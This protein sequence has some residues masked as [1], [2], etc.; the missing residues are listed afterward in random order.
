MANYCRAV[1]KGPRGTGAQES[2]PRNRL[3]QAG[4]RFLGSLKRFLNSGSRGRDYA[5]FVFYQ[6]VFRVLG[7]GHT[8][9]IFLLRVLSIF[10]KLFNT[11]IFRLNFGKKRTRVFCFII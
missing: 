4:N 9:L 8:N 10:E 7:M 5:Q 2:I 6:S 3:R 11:K 1:T